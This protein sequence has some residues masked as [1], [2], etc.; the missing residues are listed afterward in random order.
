MM[1]II[2]LFYFPL[3]SSV[4]RGVEIPILNTPS[5]NQIPFITTSSPNQIPRTLGK[6]QCSNFNLDTN[7]PPSCDFILNQIKIKSGEI[8]LESKDESSVI[9]GED[10]LNLFSLEDE[11]NVIKTNFTKLEKHFNQ[12]LEND[13]IIL[14][15]GIMGKMELLNMIKYQKMRTVDPNSIGSGEFSNQEEFNKIAREHKRNAEAHID[16][17]KMIY[18]RVISTTISREIAKKFARGGD[19]GNQLWVEIKIKFP[20]FCYYTLRGDE[21]EVTL[22]S[23]TSIT[24]IKIHL[25]KQD[26]PAR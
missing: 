2:F 26:L 25:K 10:I 20:K 6:V 13:E 11:K 9:K 5:P 18:T 23:D 21:K 24:G 22:P 15:R 1:R 16:F 8:S 12:A 19:D 4:G 7:P 3:F 17:S 14:F